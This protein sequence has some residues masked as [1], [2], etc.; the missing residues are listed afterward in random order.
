MI[1]KSIK[2]DILKMT[3][4]FRNPESIFTEVYKKHSWGGVSL[5]GPGS[6]LE[7][8]ITLRK[9]LPKLLH[10]LRVTSILDIPCGDFNW[11][12]ELDLGFIS[13]IG[14]DIVDDLVVHNKEKYSAKNRKFEKI[15]ILNDKLPKVDLIFSRDLFV[16]FSN[17]DVQKAIK[18]IKESK[19]EFLLTTSF[20]SKK[21]NKDIV[22]GEW[23]S[24]NL[25]FPPFSFPKPIKIINENYLKEE[26][27][28]D[29]S[30]LLWK[31]KDLREY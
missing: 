13:Y 24:I 11:L 19:S 15:N 10:E 9:E 20:I 6:D 29:K 22:T 26:K 4:R 25:L 28:T 23:R 2:K 30:L 7:H 1:Y 31:V 8:T 14:A 12:K 18:N 27:Y 16:H 21:E 17:K 3:K 5:S